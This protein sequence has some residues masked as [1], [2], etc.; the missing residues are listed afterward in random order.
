MNIARLA[1][2]PVWC[3][4]RLLGNAYLV[5]GTLCGDS[6]GSSGL[7]TAFGM[8]DARTLRPLWYPCTAAK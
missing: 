2:L 8:G 5:R 1:V 7:M 6:M 3:E 4:S